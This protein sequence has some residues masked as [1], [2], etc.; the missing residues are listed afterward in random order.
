MSTPQ[1]EYQ[2]RRR[3]GISLEEYHRKLDA[4]PHCAICGV[5]HSEVI[6]GLFLD[7]NHETEQLRDFLC[8]RCNMLVGVWE[9]NPSLFQKVVEYTQRHSPI[10]PITGEF[11]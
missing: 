2:I 3:Y 11:K 1:I 5:H 9:K 6:K 7:H 4:Q 10:D 8:H